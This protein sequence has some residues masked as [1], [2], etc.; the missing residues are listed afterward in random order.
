MQDEEEVEKAWTSWA[1]SMDLPGRLPSNMKQISHS[2]LLV[3]KKKKQYLQKPWRVCTAH[4]SMKE[5][6]KSGKMLLSRPLSTEED[7]LRNS[8]LSTNM[9]T[10]V[11]TH[12]K[13]KKIYQVQK[14]VTVYMTSHSLGLT[15]LGA[16][17]LS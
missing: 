6:K 9:G 16:G 4:K 11:N 12:V 8:T 15:G 1:C 17:A 2:K 5:W 3:Q 13:F 7:A 14:A 10:V